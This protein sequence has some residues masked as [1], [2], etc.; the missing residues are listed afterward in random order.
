MHLGVQPLDAGI[1]NS[2]KSIYR[3]ILANRCIELIGDDIS[4][5]NCYNDAIRKI[6]LLDHLYDIKYAWSQVTYKTIT[7]CWRKVVEFNIEN[8]H[9][10]L[11]NDDITDDD[12][13]HEDLNLLD[14]E[15]PILDKLKNYE[16]EEEE[17]EVINTTEL[18]NA[19]QVLKGAV[20]ILNVHDIDM[21]NFERR[22][23]AELDKRSTQQSITRY[24][25]RS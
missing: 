16:P 19:I 15:I 17:K 22:I 20:S 1:I 3:N 21:Y 13:Q 2:F 14:N 5:A 10:I 23:R 9:T 24:L 18:F 4:I 12:L 6:T 11:E 8:M 7:N 25:G